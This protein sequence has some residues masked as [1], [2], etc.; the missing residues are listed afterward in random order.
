MALFDRALGIPS[1]AVDSLSRE[2]VSF[3]ASTAEV[4]DSLGAGILIY[5]SSGL[6]LYLNTAGSNILGVQPGQVQGRRLEDLLASPEELVACP[7]DPSSPNRSREMEIATANGRRTRIGYQLAPL[8]PTA[9]A[10]V[11]L[12]QDINHVAQMRLERDRLMRLALVSELLPT[13]AH[14]IK[15]PL[16]GIQSLVEV[17]AQEIQEP[18]QK[19]DLAAILAELERLRLIIDGLGLADG[20]LCEP[21]AGL[22]LARTV[23]DLF[24]LN[25][26]RARHLGVELVE[27]IPEGLT[28][29]L[30]PAML[31][32]VLLNLLNNALD[33][34]GRGDKVGVVARVERGW[35]Y[36][37]VVDTGCG[38]DPG[39]LRR[40][41]EAFFT[42]RQRGSGIGLALVSQVTTRSGGHLSISSTPGD[43]T[44][45]TLKLPHPEPRSLHSRAGRLS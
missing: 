3:P 2:R 4:L 19:S 1:H 38:M 16:A 25:A 41:T 8:G 15:N 13:L 6:I 11:V 45:V 18:D 14:E 37:E 34:C 30:N 39:V 10:T 27:R 44:T 28:L 7:E 35:S 43:G 23:R 33:A 17:L 12:F 9:G 31:R 40:A 26:A 20:D 29:D 36:I 24:R 32:M 5:R 42:T 21:G 22:D